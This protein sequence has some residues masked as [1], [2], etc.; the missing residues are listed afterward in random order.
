MMSM[1]DK[2]LLEQR[3]RQ[4]ERETRDNTLTDK[5]R[6]YIRQFREERDNKR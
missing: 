1:H 4:V 6:F 5:L 3:M 2:H